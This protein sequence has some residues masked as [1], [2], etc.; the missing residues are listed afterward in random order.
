VQPNALDVVQPSG[1]PVRQGLALS[2]RQLLK[3]LVAIPLAAAALS[4][5]VFV[6][7]AS[8]EVVMAVI[9]VVGIVLALVR[10]FGNSA[11]GL[12]DLMAL[13]LRLLLNISAQLEN[14][15]RG[16][17]VILTRLDDLERL[18]EAVPAK[19]VEE[20]S[21]SRILGVSTLYGEMM[22]ACAAAKADR[23]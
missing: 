23:V 11:P 5:P 20:M 16:I 19:T 15:Q 1:L 13:Q 18:V 14:V 4:A 3:S 9:A 12:G 21:K 22:Q 7:V 6:G 2:R 17:N 10:L 8:A